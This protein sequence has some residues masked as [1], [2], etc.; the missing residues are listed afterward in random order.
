MMIAI[1]IFTL[2]LSMGI[3][4]YR[5][6]VQNTQIRNA[7]ESIE[8]GIQRARAEAVKRNVNIE[9]VLGA[10]YP[11]KI[12]LNGNTV[13]C[14]GEPGFDPGVDQV[15]GTLLVC[16]T[17]EGFKNATVSAIPAGPPAA[18]TITFS[19]L[20][21]V[22]ANTPASATLT[23]IDLDTSVQG[24]SL[25]ELRKLRVAIGPG[26]NPRVC[27]PNFSSSSTDPRRCY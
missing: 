1:A 7:A 25:T 16:S 6:W 3:P 17:R 4:S 10:A 8:N 15:G 27:D 12:Q 18:T 20:G 19:S 14:P 23:Q 5:T 11:W 24:S 2:A 9:F 22:V 13:K 26:G 21:T